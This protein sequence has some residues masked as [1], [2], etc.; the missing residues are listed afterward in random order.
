MVW[1]NEFCYLQAKMENCG[2]EKKIHI[3]VGFDIYT[4]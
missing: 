1:Q 3:I 2:N 4:K